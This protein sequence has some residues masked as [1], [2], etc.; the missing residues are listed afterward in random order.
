M[1]IIFIVIRVKAPETTSIALKQLLVCS[2]LGTLSSL[3]NEVDDTDSDE[4]DEEKVGRRQHITLVHP[5]DHLQLIWVATNE[6]TDS[7]HKHP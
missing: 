3:S 6:E 4:V 7:A 1:G 2:M 5:L